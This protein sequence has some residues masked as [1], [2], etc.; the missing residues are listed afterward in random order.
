LAPDNTD[1][2]LPPAFF[3]P[4]IPGGL[5]G[6]F[7]SGA[8][9]G[10]DTGISIVFSS[11]TQFVRGSHV[12]FRGGDRTSINSPITISGIGS[13]RSSCRCRSGSCQTTLRA[14]SASFIPEWKPRNGSKNIRQ[15][16]SFY[17]V[18]A[19]E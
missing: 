19:S 6:L 11:P 3:R 18:V 12:R 1:M 10:T 2:A 15:G 16:R 7:V 8:I 14:T 5:I 17:F 13:P 9:G 4:N